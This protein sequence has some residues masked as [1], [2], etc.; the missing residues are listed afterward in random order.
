LALDGQGDC[1]PK[2]LDVLGRKLL[3]RRGQAFELRLGRRQALL[4]RKL[5]VIQLGEG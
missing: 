1:W 2:P 3:A 5:V 4:P